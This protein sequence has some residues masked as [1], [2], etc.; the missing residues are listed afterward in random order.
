MRAAVSCATLCA[1]DLA[2]GILMLG[3]FFGAVY[4]SARRGRRRR[5]WLAKLEEELRTASPARAAE[6]RSILRTERRRDAQTQREIEDGMRRSG[7]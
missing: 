1:M 6:L 5:E 4:W 3:S 2:V 7:D